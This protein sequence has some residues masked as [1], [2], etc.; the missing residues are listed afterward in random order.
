MS[1][2]N[3][4]MVTGNLTKD[5][6]NKVTTSGTPIME[7]RIAVNDW[8]RGADGQ[9]Q[10]VAGYYDCTMFGNRAETLSRY[11]TKGSKVALKGKLHWES[12]EKDGQARSRV[13]IIV[14]DLEFMSKGK[15]ASATDLANDDIPF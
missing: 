12:W 5:P 10:D 6:I 14:D 13:T 2:L 4:V 11:L 1:N 9:G 7:F 15:Q 3:I 8:K